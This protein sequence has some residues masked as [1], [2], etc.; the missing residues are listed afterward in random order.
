M[1]FTFA[2]RVLPSVKT[3]IVPSSALISAFSPA[4]LLSFISASA[5]I[6]ALP[7]KPTFSFDISAMFADKFAF[8]F[9]VLRL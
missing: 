1:F 3:S 2:S 9:F 8:A 4:K 7:F 6:F 5:F